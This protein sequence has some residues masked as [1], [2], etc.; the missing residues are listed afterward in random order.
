MPFPS[1][2]SPPSYILDAIVQAYGPD[3]EQNYRWD[4]ASQALW[5]KT[6]G[7]GQ[8]AYFGDMADPAMGT[9]VVYGPGSTEHF[10]QGQNPTLFLNAGANY[11]DTYGMKGAVPGTPLYNQLAADERTRNQQGILKVGALVGGGAALGATPWGS[12]AG[13]GTGSTGYG[14][15]TAAGTDIAPGYAAG[16]AGGSGLGGVALPASASY[17]SPIAAGVGT[18]ADA[19][20]AGVGTGAGGGFL[21]SLFGGGSGAG[22]SSRLPDIINGA[23]ALL[24]YSTANRAADA[25][26][27]G[28][29]DAIAENARQYDT[30]RADFAPWMKAGVNALGKLEDP[31]A[32]FEAS[33]DYGFRRSEGQRDVGNSFA[34]RGGAFSGNALK[35][36]T[37]YNSNLAKGEFGDWWN[38]QAG[39]AGVGQAAT[40]TVA[41]AGNAASGRTS[42]L[43][44]DNGN[45]RAS[46]ITGANS[47][48]G[49]GLQDFLGNWLYKNRRGYYGG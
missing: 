37:E 38:R 24:G 40:G 44:A 29:R 28:N 23:N 4:S 49:Y 6:S 27:A 42:N 11:A 43:L 39:L 22:A 21:S 36:L 16:G 5:N 26:Q 15:G 3:W 12:G 45:I 10:D 30:T 33:P 47:A 41:S 25:A 32:N 8:A 14:F 34:A 46:G 17:L 35:A 1:A 20:A 19:A 7:G 48:L 9:N 18:T 31:N 2:D 13:A